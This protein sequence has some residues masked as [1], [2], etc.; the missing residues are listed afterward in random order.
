MKWRHLLLWMAS[1]LCGTACD[2]WATPRPPEIKVEVGVF[3]GGQLQKR[4]QWPLVLDTTRQTQGFRVV[5]RDP[6]SAEAPLS[7]ELARPR[8]DSKRRLQQI[9][10]QYQAT[11]PVGTKTS[12]QLIPFDEADRPGTWRL[13]IMLRNQQVFSGPLE[14][15]RASPTT[16][17]D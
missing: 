17:D 16:A 1:S 14:V 5:L 13:K 7:W 10:S 11:L 3:F 12:D 6:L 9:T 15:Q 8:M 2:S 4:N